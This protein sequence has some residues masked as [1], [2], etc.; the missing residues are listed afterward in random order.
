MWR[1]KRRAIIIAVFL[2]VFILV[3]FFKVLP[4]ILPVATCTDG[5]RNQLE[6]DIDCGGECEKVCQSEYL[7]IT[8]DLVKA[9][10]VGTSTYKIFG[11]LKNSNLNF[12]PDEIFYT[13]YIYDRDGNKKELRG[14]VKVPLGQ[15]TPILIED[16]R[17][18][19]I[20]KV[21]LSIDTYTMKRGAKDFSIVL[22]D[23]KF[24]N[25][26]TPKIQIF[27]TSPYR[28]DRLNQFTLFV[29]LKDKNNNVVTVEKTDIKGLYAGKVDN[30]FLSFKNKFAQDIS[31][32][33]LVPALYE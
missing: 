22:K 24:E 30:F 10:N 8:I 29:L 3:V 21:N 15:Y 14:S 31:S 28:V 12:K 7:P 32:V 2:M 13:F 5:I 4:K 20:S 6:I 9:I 19:N 23:F 27:Y 25:T 1:Q 33:V 26:D 18:D 11:I 17:T 16:Y